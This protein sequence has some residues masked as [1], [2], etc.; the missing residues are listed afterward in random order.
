M[1]CLIH[2]SVNIIDENKNTFYFFWGGGLNVKR[3]NYVSSTTEL[4]CRGKEDNGRAI[5][6]QRD[7]Q[8]SWPMSGRLCSNGGGFLSGSGSETATNISQE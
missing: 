2:N 1:A 7:G 5:V 8:T 6:L 3:T 4:P